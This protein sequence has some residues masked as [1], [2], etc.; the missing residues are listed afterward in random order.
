[1]SKVVRVD[2][3]QGEPFRFIRIKDLHFFRHLLR[4][5]DLSLVKD[6][7]T[8][9]LSAIPIEPHVPY[10]L[11]PHYLYVPSQETP[12]KVTNVDGEQEAMVLRAGRPIPEWV[13][14]F[15]I[16]G[17]GLGEELTVYVMARK[18]VVIL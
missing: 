12:I 7:L 1:M 18:T 13:C 11:C 8:T 10:C 15:E 3:L 9:A 16:G 17:L 2:S 6:Y 5:Y 4:N 14:E